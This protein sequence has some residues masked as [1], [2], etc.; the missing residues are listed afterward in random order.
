LLAGLLLTSIAS[1]EPPE[2]IDINQ[3]TT[4][5]LVKVKGIGLKTAEKILE[6]RDANGPFTRMGQ[7]QEVK[8]VGK[9]TLGKLVCYFYVEEEGRLPCEVATIRHG[10]ERVNIN[11]A[12]AKGLQTLP[13]IGAKRAGVIVNDRST[14]GLFHSV[15]DLQRIKGIGRGTVQKLTPLVDVHLDINSARGA[16]FEALGIANG[17]AIVK[18]RAN[19]GKFSTV[20]DLKKVPGI[21]GDH[22][23]KIS[24]YMRA[25]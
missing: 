24:K 16:E 17:D 13:G 7:V 2:R 1:A 21:D 10:G 23:D 19:H 12:T 18:F 5:D 22:I 25:K 8:G 15:D 3:A 14:N 9:A 20:E 4:A 11:T 6:R